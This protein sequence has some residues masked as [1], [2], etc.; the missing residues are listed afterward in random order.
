METDF[1][2]PSRMDV[3]LSNFYQLFLPSL[4][5]LGFVP[6]I[7]FILAYPCLTAFFFFFNDKRIIVGYL[8]SREMPQLKPM[9]AR[10]ARND[11]QADE[12]AAAAAVRDFTFSI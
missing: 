3:S 12:S 1:F 9:P 6:F 5:L 4:W 8:E 2:L 11:P 10:A 7:R